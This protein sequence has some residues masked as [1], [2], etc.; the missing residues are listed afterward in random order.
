M[1]GERVMSGLNNYTMTADWG[2]MSK[3]VFRNNSLDN[4]VEDVSKIDCFSLCQKDM[5]HGAEC[6]RDSTKG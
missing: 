2:G 3:L 5:E 1:E 6:H 4:G